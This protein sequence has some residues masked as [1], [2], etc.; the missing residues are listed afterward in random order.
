M[1]DEQIPSEI[2]RVVCFEP[3]RRLIIVY[4]YLGRISTV[5]VCSSYGSLHTSLSLS[6]SLSL[7][8]KLNRTEIS[9]YFYNSIFSFLFFRNIRKSFLCLTLFHFYILSGAKFEPSK[10]KIIF[11]DF[12]DFFFR[13]RENKGRRRTYIERNFVSFLYL[14]W[15]EI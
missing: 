1:R 15:R 12:D 5:Y 8:L 6:L 10:V 13:R 4:I 7:A 3:M 11:E 9:M 14:E 2:V